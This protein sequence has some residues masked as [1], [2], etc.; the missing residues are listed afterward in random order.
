MLPL[1]FFSALLLAAPVYSGRLM[2]YEVEHGLYTTTL[3]ANASATSFMAVHESSTKQVYIFGI[4]GGSSED[5]ICRPTVT[6]QIIVAPRGCDS[7]D[8]STAVL[9]A[10]CGHKSLSGL[11]D[12]WH[13]DPTSDQCLRGGAEATCLG[14]PILAS[15]GQPYREGVDWVLLLQGVAVVGGV[16]PRCSIPT[17]TMVNIQLPRLQVRN[18]TCPALGV[19]FYDVDQAAAQ[20]AEFSFWLLGTTV[21]L[22]PVS[23]IAVS[24]FG[25][26]QWSWGGFQRATDLGRQVN[27]T[28]CTFWADLVSAPHPLQYVPLAIPVV[29]NYY[30]NQVGVRDWACGIRVGKR[31]FEDG[32]PLVFGMPEGVVGGGIPRFKTQY[33]IPIRVEADPRYEDFDPDCARFY[34]RA[35]VFNGFGFS[36]FD[37]PEYSRSEP[38]RLTCYAPFPYPELILELRTRDSRAKQ[39]KMLGGLLATRTAD[40]C[41]MDSWRTYCRRGWLYFDERCWYKFDDTRDA[42]SQVPAG[43]DSNRVCAALNPNAIATFAFPI[44]VSAWLQRFFVY[45]KWPNTVTRTIIKGGRCECYGGPDALVVSCNCDDPYFPLCSYHVKDDPIPWAHVDFHP[46]TLDLLQRG[47]QGVAQGGAE[48]LCDCLAGSRGPQCL[49]PTCITPIDIDTSVNASL[50]NPATMF[51]KRCY[52]QGRGYCLDGHPYECGCITGYGPPANLVTGDYEET[53][54]MFPALSV[55]RAGDGEIEIDGV[56]TTSPYGVC[57]FVERGVAV[58]GGW[59]D[60]RCL[61]NSRWSATGAEEPAFTGRACPCR[62]PHYQEGSPVIETTCNRRGTCCPGGERHDGTVGYCPSGFD[63]CWCDDGYAGESCTARAPPPAK[64]S[65]PVALVS[66]GAAIRQ[67]VR[68]AIAKIYVSTSGGTPTAVTMYDDTITRE[69]GCECELVDAEAWERLDQWST[70][71]DCSPA[72]RRWYA[73][74]ETDDALDLTFRLYEE[75]YNLGGYYPNLYS[76]RFFAIREFQ[77]QELQDPIFSKWGSTTGPSYCSPG[78]VGQTC[79]IGISAFRRGTSPRQCGDSTE[80]PRGRVV[81][82]RC[83]G[84]G[85][86]TGILFT[87]NAS[88]CALVEGVMCAGK[89]TCLEPR[90]PWGSCSQD[91]DLLARDPLR[92]PYSPRRPYAVVTFEAGS[93][94]AFESVQHTLPAGFQAQVW[95]SLMGDQSTDFSIC[96]GPVAIP[97]GIPYQVG[98]PVPPGLY[99][100]TLVCATGVI[101]V[102]APSGAPDCSNPVHRVLGL[103]PD[104][105]IGPYDNTLGLGY[106]LFVNLSDADFTNATWDAGQYQ[107]LSSVLGGCRRNFTIEDW[108]AL[109]E[110]TLIPAGAPTYGPSAGGGSFVLL[111]PYQ[112]VP[113]GIQVVGAGGSA[114]GWVLGALAANQSYRVPCTTE[115]AVT[116]LPASGTWVVQYETDGPAALTALLVAGEVPAQGA[117]NGTTLD[118]GDADD[119]AYLAAVYRTEFAP[120]RCAGDLQC[121][122]FSPGATCRPDDHIPVPWLGGDE[123]DTT[124]VI[125]HEGGCRCMSSPEEGFFLQTAFCSQCVP[126][127]GPGDP[128]ELFAIEKMSGLVPDWVDPE[129]VIPCSLPV[130]PT[131]TRPSTVCGGRGYPVTNSTEETIEV[132]VI[133][134]AIRRCRGL[135]F[136]GGVLY[137]VVEADASAPWMS[138]YRHEGGAIVSAVRGD[139]YGGA[140]EL[141]DGWECVVAESPL[142]HTRQEG[143]GDLLQRDTFTLEIQPD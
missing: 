134:G 62:V 28:N 72:C 137:Q 138:S 44:W 96:P 128:S 89:G 140:G 37:G 120:R 10:S 68:V 34:P 21:V 63:G 104:E 101:A 5:V 103:C 95:D 17:V 16:G 132:S 57:G 81:A 85:I 18:S 67:A 2:V 130:D 90:F 12:Y 39:C 25:V 117:C 122:L 45:W 46:A 131:S 94:I 121:S 13:L 136:P 6:T 54:C 40:V 53:P 107:F 127:Y 43:P 91:I 114:C 19:G 50:R 58:T 143:L 49:V 83:E 8:E 113:G 23:G 99:N 98:A 51:F 84:N 82:E 71:W 135:R 36:G 30:K 69:D 75:S 125:G 15:T 74:A 11:L 133:Q 59:N 52:T 126:G 86:G 129:A 3:V 61:C 27:T 20:V 70:R 80:P 106:G 9:R 118:T 60:G 35:E 116:L 105:P 115:G 123:V 65:G 124:D 47:Q 139:V 73:L 79:A 33:G 87:G 29:S 42:A 38:A 31:T 100:I 1:L 110:H 77:Y 93:L 142:Y 112:D 26:P 64:T 56:V 102:H 32:R 76:A 7:R 119:Q 66:G 4:S 88:Q 78:Y 92:T 111:Q 55:P 41:S 14:P 97:M 48:I 141:L 109:V 22:G 24:S 108:D